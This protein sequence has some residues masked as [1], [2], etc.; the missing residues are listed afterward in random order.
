MERAM[1]YVVLAGL[2]GV[3]ACGGTTSDP[4]G[5]SAA[6]SN[7]GDC[8]SSDECAQGSACLR[9][10]NSFY[11]GRCTAYDCNDDKDCPL[12]SYCNGT[13]NALA[14]VNFPPELY[15]LSTPYPNGGARPSNDLMEGDACDDSHPC[16]PAPLPGNGE[17]CTDF[18]ECADDAYCDYDTFI[19]RS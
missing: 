6:V 5:D 9:L 14:G 10:S 15:G 13:I 2:V 16:P 3:S 8:M 7:G 18:G 1:R 11:Q 17:P 12:T 19:C 4:S